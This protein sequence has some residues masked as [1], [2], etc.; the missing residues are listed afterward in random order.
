MPTLSAI[1][2]DLEITFSSS[3][4]LGTGRAEGLLDRT[5]RRGAGGEAYVPASALKGALREAAER[6]TRR[7]DR[8]L[9]ELGAEREQR[10]GLRRRADTVLDEPCRA[11]RAEA[12]CQSRAPC[13]VCRLFGNVFTGA[14]LVVDDAHVVPGP[15]GPPR[16]ESVTRLAIDRRRRGAKKGALF[17]SEYSRPGPTYRSRL[18]G[19]VPLSPIEGDGVPAELVVLAGALRLARQ[20]G[21]EGSTGHGQCHVRL[22]GGRLRAGDR[23]YETDALLGQLE[24]VVFANL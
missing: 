22:G 19:Q 2:A 17:S 15:T 5:V 21:A 10:F 11:P 24:N 20:V 12:M 18:A 9:V 16:H 3:H 4:H 23:T 6:L 13:I 8:Q 14:R 7:L 1:D